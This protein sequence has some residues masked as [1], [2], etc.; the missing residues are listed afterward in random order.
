[1]SDGTPSHLR[2]V[3]RF[4]VLA[5]DEELDLARRSHDH[6]ETGAAQKLVTSHLRLVAKIAMGYRG[7]GLPVGD[8]IGEGSV[9]VIQAIKRFDPARGFRLATYA[10][11]WIRA[12]MQEYILRTSSLVKIGTTTAQKKLFFNL[13]R[14]K[15]EIQAIGDPD[16]KPEQVTAKALD[17]PEPNVVSMNQRPTMPDYSHNAPVHCD[18]DGERQDWLVDETESQETNTAELTW[19][20]PRRQR[21]RELDIEAVVKASRAIS[22]EIALPR[23]IERLLTI[24]LQNA[25]ADRGLLLLPKPKE[26]YRIEAEAWTN[27]GEVVLRHKPGVDSCVPETLIRC[28][29]RSRKKVIVD[30]ALEPNLFSEDDDL[31]R[32][33]PRSLLC[34]PLVRQGTFIGLLYLENTLTSHVFNSGRTAVLELL[35]SQAAIALENAGLHSELQEREARLREIQME[36]AHANRVATMG[37]LSASI[38]HEVKQPI[39]AA[40]TNAHAASRWLAAHPP[41]L[42][43]AR[44]ALARIVQDGNRAS[45]IMERIRAL[46]KRAPPQTDELAIN[47]AILEIMPL[48]RTEVLKNNVLLQMQ[49]GADLPLILGDRVQLQQVVLNLIVNAIEAMSERR[50]SVRELLVRTATAR[51]GAVLVSVSDSGPGLAPEEV[52]RLFEAFYTTKPNGL[53][54]GLS[55]CR[56]I[57]EAHGGRLWVTANEPKGAVFQFTL[58]VQPTAHYVRS[59]PHAVRAYA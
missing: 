31:R 13:R 5:A 4:P 50:Q 7:C 49:L 41:G 57:I 45:N 2:A 46:V 25:G 55:I 58:P 40:V 53:G 26:G 18:T 21:G 36:L 8:L 27:G 14:V 28:A 11:Y 59:L 47:E 34:L 30:D 24:A 6:H 35:A 9:G 16:M 39:A 23:L 32:R 12:A 1:M 20:R 52:E 38:V 15:S 29:I 51:S 19:P 17:L 56:S 43:K 22:S 33:R 3:H 54:V 37:Q 42:E 44:Q 48:T 10:T